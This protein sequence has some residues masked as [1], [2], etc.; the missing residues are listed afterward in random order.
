MQRMERSTEILTELQEIASFLGQHGYPRVTY[1]VPAGFFDNFPRIL[2]ERIRQEESK[3]MEG[4]KGIA[5]MSSGQET[6]EISALLAGLQGKNPYQ[7]PEGYFETL[8]DRMSATEKTPVQTILRSIPGVS[9]GEPES[10]R[11]TQAIPQAPVVNF[12]RIIK[13]SVAACIVA[14]LG[15]NLLNI[16]Y[17]NH[18]FS[19]PIVGLKSVSSQDMANYLDAYD[20][21]WTPGFGSSSETA[22]VDLSDSDIH[23]LFSNVGDD[24]LEQYT[25]PLSDEKGTVN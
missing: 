15:L 19:D 17:R 18:P 21:H 25:L 3:D 23:A 5:E 10:A 20:V 4:I 7:V 6:A 9:T 2:M 1:T 22:S 13:Y 12:S 16:S 8:P 24:E 11:G 14:L